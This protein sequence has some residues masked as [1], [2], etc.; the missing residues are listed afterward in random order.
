MRLTQL[1]GRI[2]ISGSLSV[3]YS[4]HGLPEKDLPILQ[5]AVGL[6][7]EVLLTGDKAHFGHLFGTEVEG[8]L[9]LTA[10]QFINDLESAKLI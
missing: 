4:D 5:A 9:V 6:S 10:S 3:L 8:T 7:C 2:E 1:V